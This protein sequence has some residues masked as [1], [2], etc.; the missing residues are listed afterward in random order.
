MIKSK[1]ITKFLWN[2]IMIN[3]LIEK[4]KEVKDFRKNRGKRH[5]LWVVL[6]VIILALLTGN[7]TYKQINDFRKNQEDDLIK[8]LGITT[9]HLPSYSTIRRVMMQINTAEIQLVFA[10][11]VEKYYWLK[12]ASDVIAIDGKSLKNTLTNY[13][14]KDQNILVVVSA[15]SQETNLVIKTEC[16]ESKQ[17]SETAQVLSLI[18]NCGLINKVFTLDALHCNR[19]TT[20]AIIDSQNDYLITVKGNQKK[21]YNRLKELAKTEKP[22]S[23][24]EE[25][26]VSHGRAIQ[27]KI[28]VFAGEK[29]Q[30]KNYPH[31]QSFITVERQGRRGNKEYNETL[32][33]ISS[34]KL[35]AEIAAQIIKG[36][37]LIENRLHWVKDVVF[38]EDKSKFKEPKVAATYSLLV[39][40]ILNIYRSLGLVSI[41]EGMSWLGKA[42]QKIFLVDKLNSC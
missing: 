7:I 39:T 38:Q 3:S 36:H 1:K 5:E 19:E 16:F 40:I 15:F 30:Q 33:Y 28:S 13:E 18:R 14:N 26:E 17:M 4:L 21:I 37:W 8:F 29:V 25:K 11:M 27:R 34:Q 41:S 31:L 22:L 10:A 2:L 32:Y 12:S 6:T 23:V 35:L 42:W 20:A 24:Y 9:K